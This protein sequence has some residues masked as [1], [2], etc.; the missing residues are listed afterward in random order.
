MCWPYLTPVLTVTLTD[1]VEGAVWPEGVTKRST[2]TSLLRRLQE[3][4]LP[5]EAPLIGKIHPFSKMA[6]TFEPLK[7]F[8]CPSGFRKVTAGKLRNPYFCHIFGMERQFFLVEKGHVSAWPR[9]FIWP[10]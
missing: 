7:G 1:G 4:T 8:R 5:D 10:N 2:E 9:I 3:Q 6:V